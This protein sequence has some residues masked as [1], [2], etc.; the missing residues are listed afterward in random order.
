VIE[1]LLTRGQ[2]AAYGITR[3]GPSAMLDFVTVA[4]VFFYY[5]FKLLPGIYTGLSFALGYLVSAVCDTG[6]GYISDR[7]PTRRWGRRKPYMFIGAPL[8]A[9]CWFMYFVPTL[10]V[11]PS[12]LIGLFVWATIWICLFRMFYSFAMTPYQCWMPEVTEPDERPTVSAWQNGANFF[13]F[14]L[15]L[16]SGFLLPSILPKGLVSTPLLVIILVI[17]LI[18]LIGFLPVLSKIRGE[19]KFIKQP[20]F[21]RDYGFA[22]HH[23]NYVLW[24]IV[25]GILSFAFIMTESIALQ[26][27]SSVAQLTLIQYAG[28]LLVFLVVILAFFVIWPALIRR[29]GKRYTLTV[30]MLIVMVAYPFTLFVGQVPG[31][32]LPTYIQVYIVLALI[33]TGIAGF[34][35]LPYVAYADFAQVDQIKTGEGR[36]GVYTGFSSIPLNIFQFFSALLLGF[37]LDLPNATGK[38]FSAGLLW[39]GPVSSLF[40]ILGLLVLRKTDIDPDFAALEKEYGRKTKKE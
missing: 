31:F 34:F 35:L 38:S 17:V 7:T 12:D 33:T 10:F 25:Q 29:R 13:A 2:R 20:S 8:M 39:W 3:F 19:G 23:R 37:L 22:L 9:L 40:I 15:A 26:Y 18:E 30:S 1:K 27:L 5:G 32:P 11:S 4:G 14:G 28:F 16:A 36:A 24:I 21:R 6:F